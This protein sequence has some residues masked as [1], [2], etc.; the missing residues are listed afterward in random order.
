MINKS[1]IEKSLDKREYKQAI[2]IRLYVLREDYVYDI[3][4]IFSFFVYVYYYTD[5]NVKNVIILIIFQ[6]NI[7]P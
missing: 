2:E 6:T 4:S 1:N 5:N 3:L 7:K